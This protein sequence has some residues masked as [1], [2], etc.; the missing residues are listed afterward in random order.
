MKL[1][2]ARNLQLLASCLAYFSTL[3]MKVIC[4]SETSVFLRTKRRY[5]QEDRTLHSYHHENLKSNM[6]LLIH[7]SVCPSFRM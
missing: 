3:K 6:Y 7:Q 4:S 1:S 5:S 2:W